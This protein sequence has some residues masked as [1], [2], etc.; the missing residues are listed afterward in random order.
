MK[1]KSIMTLAL[2][3]ILITVIFAGPANADFK[4]IECVV[5]EAGCNID[6]GAVEIVLFGINKTNKKTFFLSVADGRA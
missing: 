4:W 6:T 5:I 3:F 1:N 2:A